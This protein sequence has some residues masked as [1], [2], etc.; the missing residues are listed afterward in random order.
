MAAFC[1]TAWKMFSLGRTSDDVF[2]E[3][4]TAASHGH[5]HTVLV[6]LEYV[7]GHFGVERLHHC[8]SGVAVVVDVVACCKGEIRCRRLRPAI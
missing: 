1:S 7:V 5:S 6:V 2:G 8:Q 3:Y 4:I